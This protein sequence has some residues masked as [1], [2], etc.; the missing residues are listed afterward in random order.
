[1][2]VFDRLS[3]VLRS[4]LSDSN[5]WSDT[6]GDYDGRFS[7]DQ[8][9]RQ[10]FEELDQFLNGGGAYAGGSGGDT[11]HGGEFYRGAAREASGPRPK[12][13][14]PE[15]LRADFAELGVEFGAGAE[16]CKAA[17]KKLLKIHHPDRHTSHEGDMNKATVKSA[18]INAAYERIREWQETG[19]I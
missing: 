15:K 9:L 2:G 14:V 4:Y 6:R 19:K 5:D 1:V 8:D 10:A 7:G 17:Y 18:K 12:P 16:Q 3:S 11:V 13:A